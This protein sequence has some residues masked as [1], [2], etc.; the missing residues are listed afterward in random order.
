MDEGHSTPQP[1]LWA[2]SQMIFKVTTTMRDI[3]ACSE[4]TNKPVCL[5]S[6]DFKDTLDRMSH[7][8]LFTILRECGIREQFCSRLQRIYANATSTLKLNCT[9]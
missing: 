4:E 5:L 1:V 2:D 9:D 6:I 7:P 3:I 8:F